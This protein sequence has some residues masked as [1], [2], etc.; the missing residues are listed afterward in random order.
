[1]T[2]RITLRSELQFTTAG[3]R[4][5]SLN[6]ALALETVEDLQAAYSGGR[7]A[8]ADPVFGGAWKRWQ[9]H[10]AGELMRRGVYSFEKRDIFGT[11][12]IEVRRW[13]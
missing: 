6:A 12:T 9:D 3:E 7:G 11:H 13:S 2:A 4:D 1:M 5:G 8:W 10:L